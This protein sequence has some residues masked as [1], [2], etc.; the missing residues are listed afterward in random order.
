[1]LSGRLLLFSTLAQRLVSG[2]ELLN[3]LIEEDG[4]PSRIR[5]MCH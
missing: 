1:M 2:V 4:Q 3:E 5:L